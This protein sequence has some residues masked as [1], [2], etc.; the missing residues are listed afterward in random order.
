[1]DAELVEYLVPYNAAAAGKAI[2]QLN[3]PPDCLIT[4]VC[5]DEKF[6][7]ASGKTVL[8]EGDVV[9]AL[10]NDSNAK[11]FGAILSRLKKPA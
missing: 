2:H 1:M 8:E 7:V 3:L 6:I 11:E 10:V 9:L 4:L 5:R